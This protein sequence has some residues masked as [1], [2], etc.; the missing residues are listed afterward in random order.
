[1]I[2]NLFFL[3]LLAGSFFPAS[4]KATASPLHSGVAGE[5]SYTRLPLAD[6]YILYHDNTYYAY[7]TSDANGI[8]V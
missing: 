5:V 6:P 7:G 1:M 8:V 2:R 3:L 4:I